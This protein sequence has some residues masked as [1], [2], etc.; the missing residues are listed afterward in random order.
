MMRV[1]GYVQFH[2]KCG[3]VIRQICS[4][5]NMRQFGREL[6][7]LFQKCGNT[8]VL[9]QNKAIPNSILKY[10]NEFSKGL[11]SFEKWFNKNVLEIDVE[12]DDGYIFSKEIV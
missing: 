11:G 4:I 10:G 7:I 12:K 2:F 8:Q 6:R 9:F 5:L 3:I 1:L